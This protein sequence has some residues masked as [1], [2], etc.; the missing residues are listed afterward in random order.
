MS[1]LNKKRRFGVW[2]GLF[3]LI[4]MFGAQILAAPRKVELK[5]YFPVAVSGSLVNA[6]EKMVAEFQQKYPD[7][8]ITPVYSG[9]YDQTMQ[10][11]QTSVM[12]GNPP[13]VCVVEISELHTLVAMNAIMPL[14]EFIK[15]EGGQKFLS[16]YYEGFLANGNYK[17]KTW[18]MPFQ[19]ST[20]VFYY[21][22]DMFK[23]NSAALRAKGMDPNRAPQTWDELVEYAKVLHKETN[24]RVDVYG[25]ILPGGWNDWIFESFVRQ[26]GSQLMSDDGTKPMFNTPEA[27]E[28]LN[29]W[30]YLTQALK[31]NPPL[32]PWNMTPDDFI[33]EKAAMM[34][35]TTGGMS[36]I[37][38]SAKFDF[39]VAFMPKKKQFG[40]PVGGG[41]LHIFRN[42]PQERQKAAWEFVKFMTDPQRAAYWSIQ[43]GYVAV[44]KKAYETPELKKY[45]QDFPQAV[46]A[47]DQLA[48]AYPKMAAVNY[49]RIRKVFVTT[50]DSVMEG[51]K[52]AADAL[53]DIQREAEA[54][55]KK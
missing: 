17:G 5:F 30:V 53:K 24:G 34:Y 38:Q 52:S 6:I 11:V 41:N 33:A 55:L 48:Y 46:V 22:K 14:D 18:G 4:S 32:R 47:R 9:D 35:Y 13:D 37:R 31:V 20:P 26:N 15:K 28:A 42:I 36:K 27:L 3:L 29:L 43:S 25:L 50:L 7:I 23:A 8:L 44:N 39:G 45:L 21:N 12:G 54:A 40:T 49:Q 19:R 16:Q 1:D 10:K 2:V 51:K